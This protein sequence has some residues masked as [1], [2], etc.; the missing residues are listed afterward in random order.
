MYINIDQE[1]GSFFL[2]YS[3]LYSY[4]QDSAWNRLDAQLLFLQ[5]IIVII[6]LHIL[7][8]LKLIFTEQLIS[9]PSTIL[10]FSAAL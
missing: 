8:I 6:I 5:H 9:M 3:L 7:K 2:S 1:D 10:S 4:A